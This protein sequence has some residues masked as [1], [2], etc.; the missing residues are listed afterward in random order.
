[1]MHEEIDICVMGDGSRKITNVLEALSNSSK[2]KGLSKI[3]GILYR[4]NGEV[5][6]TQSDSIFKKGIDLD[7]LPFPARHLLPNDKYK[8]V[9]SN[10][11]PITSML[12]SMGCPFHCIYC[13]T[14]YKTV[15]R[16]PNRVV[17]EMEYCNKKLGIK[18]ILFYDETFTL[19]KER[20]FS[21]CDLLVNK[22][23]D[24]TFSIRTRADTVTE[25]L[26]Q[27]LA[28]AGCV[29]INYGIES[30]NQKVLENIRRNIPLEQIKNAIEWTKKYGIQAFGFFMIGC[31]GDDYKTINETIDFAVSLSLDY[32][33]FNKLTLVPNSELYHRVK[34]MT[35]IDYWDEYTKGNFG[36]VETMPR[37]GVNVSDEML[38]SML[39]RAYK[40]FYYR[41]RFI[42]KQLS[43]IR[44][45]KQLI[46]LG[47]AALNILK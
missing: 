33:Q 32:V 1:M 37:Y 22:G 39:K 35:Q 20:V 41:P 23:L 28:K 15:A 8:T 3:P 21:I 29:R 31:P 16:D 47:E 38:D 17:Q 19:N 45:P 9:I 34:D 4:L 46:K 44:S 40:R 7:A 42:L 6:Q 13:D 10:R 12:S 36:I 5:V 24:L 30:G 25:E 18:E 26:I 27:Q 11:H 2:S 43:G 14:S